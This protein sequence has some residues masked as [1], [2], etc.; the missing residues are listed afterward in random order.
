MYYIFLELSGFL[1]CFYLAWMWEVDSETPELGDRG[2]GLG[3]KAR[4]GRE[5][6]EH[7]SLSTK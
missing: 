2:L 5:R 6:D 7:K 1:R 4:G 3:T